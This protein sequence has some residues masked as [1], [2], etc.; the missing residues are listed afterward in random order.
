MQFIASYSHR[1]FFYIQYVDKQM[2]LMPLNK[3]S[4]FRLP[5]IYIYIYI[6]IYISSKFA[7][8]DCK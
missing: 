6:Y 3:T 7:G 8:L 2:H 5:N 4:K 1:A